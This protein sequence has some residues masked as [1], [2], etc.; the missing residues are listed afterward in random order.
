MAKL[1]FPE[2]LG[3][4]GGAVLLQTGRMAFACYINRQISG[5]SDR[6]DVHKM[7]EDPL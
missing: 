7:I 2:S 3:E 6:V 5:I 1:C 4:G